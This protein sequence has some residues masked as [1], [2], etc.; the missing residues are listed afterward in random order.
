LKT[1][2]TFSGLFGPKIR[3]IF[4][5]KRRA[6][7]WSVSPNHAQLILEG[8]I[9]LHLPFFQP[10]LLIVSSAS[11]SRSKDHVTLSL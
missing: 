8:N 7:C 4:N 10:I 11:A 5:K 1:N 9:F 2:I 6:E 3:R